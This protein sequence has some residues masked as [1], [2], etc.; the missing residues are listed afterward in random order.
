MTSPLPDGYRLTGLDESR[1]RDIWVL[2]KW[3]FSGGGTLDELVKIPWSTPWDRMA[4]VVAPDGRDGELAAVSGSYTFERFP[5]PGGTLPCGGLTW[6]GVHPQHRR[7]GLL[8]AMIDTHFADGARRREPLQALFAA[9]EAIYP[10]FG[11]GRASDIVRLEL[12]RGAALR[13]VPGAD[14]HHVRLGDFD[15]DT[16]AE[17]VERLIGAAGHD[18]GGAPGV[19]RPGWITRDTPEFRA[20]HWYDAPSFHVRS[21]ADPIRRIA[22]V[23]RDGEPRGF[24]TFRRKADW[25]ASGPNGSVEINEVVALDAAAARAL[26]GVLLDFDLTTSVRAQVVA[27]DPVLSLLV[28][29][30]GTKPALGDALWVRL[31]DVA[32]A[33]AGRQYQGDVDVVIGVT[34]GRLPG[35]AGSWR[36]RA[37]AFGPATCERTDAEADLTIDVRD[38]A[39]AYMGHT[40]LVA[41]AAAGLVTVRTPEAL[42]RTSAAFG[43]PVAPG[44][45]VDF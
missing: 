12:G 42:G 35:N 45:V 25:G 15:L 24:A 19:N 27:D 13:D 36:L 43:W 22:I 41:L 29:R 11:Y 16:H 7:K 6:V 18:V 38:L 8:S 26:W 34:D 32:A 40:S 10:R 1:H 5:V 37:T 39:T 23:E 14:E 17:L 44:T 20:G 28:D 33:L 2:D 9:E 3:A 30:R 31:L 21:G 4:G